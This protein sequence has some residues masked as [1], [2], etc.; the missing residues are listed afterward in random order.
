MFQNKYT[1]K[2]IEI[3]RLHRGDVTQML[4]RNTMKIVVFGMKYMTKCDAQL[5]KKEN[6]LC[7]FK[8]GL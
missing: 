1:A 6:I 2:C 4:L 7:V 3:S 8:K 5:S